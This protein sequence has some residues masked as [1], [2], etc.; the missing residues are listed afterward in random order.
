MPEINNA[1]ALGVK[2]DPVDVAGTLAKAVAIREGNAKAD[3]LQQSYGERER[4]YQENGGLTSGQRATMSKTQQEAMGPIGNI[5]SNDQSPQARQQ[6]ISLARRAGIPMDDM[7]AGHLM[8]APPDQVK[9]YGMNAQRLGQ[10][11]SSNI[12]Q[13]PN[14]IAQRSQGHAGGAE[15]G[16]MYGPP[17]G[18]PTPVGSPARDGGTA[19]P[20]A[21]PAP[22]APL[23]LQERK[24]EAAGNA[25]KR[26]EEFN[27][28]R[29]ENEG[30]GVQKVALRQLMQDA[31]RVRTGAG[32]DR[33]QAA[34]KWLLAAGQLI[35]GL[36]GVADKYS[37]P[38]AAFESINKNAGLIA[39][40]AIKQVGGTAA[41]ELDAISKSLVGTETS[42]KGIQ[43]NA[44][45]L[46]GLETYKQ[47]RFQ[48]AQQYQD[49]NG[50]LKGFAA[51]FNQKAGPAAWVYMSLPAEERAKIGE[52][53]RKS[54]DGKKTL[55]SI[56]KQLDYI[57]KNKLDDSVD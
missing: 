35:P 56:A 36:Q 51:D 1:L 6:A 16:T 13:N 15:L 8:T 55:N 7:T 9:Q 31:D 28:Y 40:T 54:A 30:A 37:D 48:A 29:Q 2:N 52:T 19:G 44:S 22:T 33:E 10:S 45:Q 42:Q 32:A 5:L 26:V 12:E 25:G 50:T 14:A 43:I 23:S 34:R 3:I 47:A 17:G 39:R 41:S 27:Q 57:H 21:G 24:L 46:V 53:L 18:A 49:A 38:V 4:E 20:G 11:A